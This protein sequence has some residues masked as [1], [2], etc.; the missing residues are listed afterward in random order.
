MCLANWSLSALDSILALVSDI[1]R[2]YRKVTCGCMLCCGA[3][4]CVL[5]DNAE[6]YNAMLCCAVFYGHAY[7]EPWLS[8]SVVFVGFKGCDLLIVEIYVT[9]ETFLQGRPATCCYTKNRA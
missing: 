5:L 1:A 9:P 2:E 8:R 4:C 7:K 3:L 6:L